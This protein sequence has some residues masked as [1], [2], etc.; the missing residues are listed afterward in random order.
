MWWDIT[1]NWWFWSKL[2]I[3]WRNFSKK[4]TNK[5]ASTES[6]TSECGSD[7]EVEPVRVS[8][9]APLP[10][11]KDAGKTFHGKPCTCH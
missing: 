4:N 2:F 6:S 8:E 11:V 1:I 5:I 3:G 9:E 7:Y 10:A